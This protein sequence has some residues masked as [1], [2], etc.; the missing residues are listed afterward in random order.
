MYLSLSV[1]PSV[2][3]SLSLSVSI[4]VSLSLSSVISS[5]PYRLTFVH[6]FLFLSPSVSYSFSYDIHIYFPH[7]QNFPLLTL[8]IFL[9]SFKKCLPNLSFSQLFSQHTPLMLSVYF[10]PPSLPYFLTFLFFC[11]CFFFSSSFRLFPISYHDHPLVNGI[12]QFF[13][14]LNSLE[15]PSYSWT[16]L[17]LLAYPHYTP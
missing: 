14:Y 17:F 6:V 15:T 3:F 8:L 10:F 2:S 16:H 13:L 12:S 11:S 9:L 7:S 5:L 1:S 4:S